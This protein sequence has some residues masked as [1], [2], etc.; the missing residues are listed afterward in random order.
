EIVSGIEKADLQRGEAVEAVKNISD[1]IEETTGSAEAV[2]DV[3]QK[4]LKNVEVLNGTA[5]ALNDNMDGL[6]TEIA[7]FKV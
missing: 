2:N 7:V 4:L 6:R 3:A 1:I 5:D